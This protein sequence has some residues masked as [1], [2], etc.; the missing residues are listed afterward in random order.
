L[1]YIQGDFFVLLFFQYLF[2]ERDTFEGKHHDC[3]CTCTVCIVYGSL[4]KVQGRTGV[5]L[6]SAG[7][8][9][10]ANSGN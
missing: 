4:E 3:R 10:N 2:A 6:K 5:V 7:N 8:A 9:D 1:Y